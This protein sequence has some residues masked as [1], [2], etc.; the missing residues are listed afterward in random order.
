[1]EIERMKVAMI[2][3]YP[4][5][6]AIVPGGITSVAQTLVRGLARRTNLDVHVVCCQADVE[7]AHVESRDGATIHFLPQKDRFTQILDWAPQRRAIA[8]AL[9]D[10]RPDVVHAQGLGL[11]AAAAIDSRLP[12]AV[13]LHGI[14]WKEAGITYPSWVKRLRGRMRAHHAMRQL[15][16]TRN[17]FITSKYA[18]RMLSS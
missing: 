15:L 12:F 2:S 4:I 14:L 1:V 17:V 5:D 16:S 3:N 7:R 8:R 11:A 13:S 6:P 9:G 18:S 10:I